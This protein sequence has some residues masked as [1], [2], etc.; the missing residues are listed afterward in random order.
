MFEGC[1]I[2]H[3]CVEFV[4]VFAAVGGASVEVNVRLI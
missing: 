3:G 1:N 4:G 2:R